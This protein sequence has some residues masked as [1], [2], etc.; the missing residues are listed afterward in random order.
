MS[1]HMQEC[2][3]AQTRTQGFLHDAAC[4]NSLH[5]QLIMAPVHPWH[6]IKAWA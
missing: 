3:Q 1:V 5:E 6:V 2:A 4:V